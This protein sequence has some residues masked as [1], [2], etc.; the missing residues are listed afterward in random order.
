MERFA[1]LCLRSPMCQGWQSAAH[2]R[3]SCKRAEDLNHKWLKSLFSSLGC[4]CQAKPVACYINEAGFAP[5]GGFGDSQTQLP[6]SALSP[7]LMGIT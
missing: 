3:A 6:H 7:R 1:C 5:Q 4:I 2:I